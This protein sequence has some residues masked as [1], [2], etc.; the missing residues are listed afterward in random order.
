MGKTKFI[1]GAILGATAGA[2]LT[3]LT[4]KKGRAKLVKLGQDLGLDTGA[5]GEKAK[6]L[7][8]ELEGQGVALLKGKAGIAIK[9]SVLRRAPRRKVATKTNRE[10]N[11]QE[12]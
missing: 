11:K 10:K 5:I 6:E 9:S 7:T 4:T 12:K 1:W 8:Q 3:P 2:L